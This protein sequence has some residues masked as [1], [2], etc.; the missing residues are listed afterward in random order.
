[1]DLVQAAV[2]SFVTFTVILCLGAGVMKIFE[3]A[4]HLGDMKTVLEDIRR[5]TGAV[6]PPVSRV[7]QMGTVEQVASL[8]L[9]R[10]LSAEEYAAAL[11]P[12][13]VTQP[14]PPARA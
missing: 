8:S 12:E 11:S 1:M 3:I 2:S 14:E 7:A 5:N 9:M 6:N 13:V 4:K 10:A